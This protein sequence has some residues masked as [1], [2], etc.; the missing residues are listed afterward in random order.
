[1]SRSVVLCILDGWGHAPSSPYNATDCAQHWPRL[2]RQYPH[3]LLDASGE[4]VGLPAGQMGN[5]EVGHTTIGLGRIVEQDLPRLHRLIRERAWS[6]PSSGRCHLIVLGSKGGVHSHLDHLSA[7]IQSMPHVELWLHIFLDGRDTPPRD[8]L[9]TLKTFDPQHAKWGTI[10]GR[11]YGMDRDQR[12]DRTEKAAKAMLYGEAPHTFACP[13]DYIQSCY[14]H[15]VSDEFVEPAVHENYKGMRPGDTV[16]VLNFRADRV[17]QLVHVLH[18]FNCGQVSLPSVADLTIKGLVDYGYPMASLLPKPVYDNAMGA[19]VAAAGLTQYR[20]AETEKY[21]HVTFFLN[22]GQEEHFPGEERC[23]IPSPRVATYDMQP[24]MSAPGVLNAT[25]QAMEM[26]SLVVVNFA[27]ADMVGHTGSFQAACKAV[28]AV[29][30]CLAAL[31]RK[32]LELN[33]DLLITADH[34]NVEMMM[35]AQSR[36]HTAH[37][38]NPV[39][40]M[41]ISRQP[42]ILLRSRGT[43][44]DIAPTILNTLE[45]DVP[46]VMTG[47][48]LRL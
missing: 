48:D 23:L 19:V 12:W 17:R 18:T 45:L 4:S 25:L 39:P 14:H 15:D 42:P 46:D 43:L 41:W 21:A 8:A 3:T 26:A 11:Y 7:A 13:L 30:V 20:I 2:W 34:G 10:G 6:L 38:C 22:G 36:C 31:E 24:A 32:A 35:D 47:K 44:A 9:A 27:N 5:S 1:M 29:D 28:E 40:F 37:T 16:L 33:M